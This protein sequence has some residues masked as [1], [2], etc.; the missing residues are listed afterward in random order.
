MNLIYPEKSSYRRALKQYM[1]SMQ[2][3]WKVL[4]SLELISLVTDFTNKILLSAVS[5]LTQN[6]KKKKAVREIEQWVGFDP[7]H[8]I[9]P[10]KHYQVL[11]MSTNSRINPEHQHMWP[12]N[13]KRK[14]K[15]TFKRYFTV[16]HLIIEANIY[17][18]KLWRDFHFI[19]S[20]LF[21]SKLYGKH[22]A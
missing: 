6:Y 18:E 2:I 17:L 13:I 14:K 20:E 22:N 11:P 12:K 15:R 7:Q 4:M 10:L 3:F 21:F 8:H 5:D 9:W 16:L 19:Y 1:Y